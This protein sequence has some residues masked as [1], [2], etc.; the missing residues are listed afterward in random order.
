MSDSLN[1]ISLLEA[2]LAHKDREIEALKAD[3]IEF[4]TRLSHEL[5]TPL[6]IILGYCGLLLG[7]PLTDDQHDSLTQIQRVAD[8]LHKQT[9]QLLRLAE[10]QSR[11]LQLESLALCDLINDVLTM[12]TPMAD[13]AHVTLNVCLPNSS[14]TLTTHEESLSQ[15]LV[16]L[17]TNAIHYSPN[18]G[19]VSVTCE[20][21]DDQMK[22][23]VADEG[24]GIPDELKDA[25]F[26]L[27]H[28]RNITHV[29][30]LELGLYLAKEYIELLGGEIGFDST[31]RQGAEFWITLPT[32]E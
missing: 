30:G 11:P 23:I 20:Q 26:N 7:E 19:K 27:F 10:T 12:V 15:V 3:Q 25:V 22:I 17:L 29:E 24:E 4:L 21:N 32:R 14:L 28:D 5:N 1:H 31:I 6:N 9:A 8:Y 16:N 2:Q 18:N 13:K